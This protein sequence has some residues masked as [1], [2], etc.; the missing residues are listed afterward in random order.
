LLIAAFLGLGFGLAIAF[1]FEYID[2][3]IK[4]A[5]EVER[6]LQLPFLGMIPAAQW[7]PDTSAYIASTS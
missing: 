3:S 1:F 2:D 5:E 7:N 4:L 6:D